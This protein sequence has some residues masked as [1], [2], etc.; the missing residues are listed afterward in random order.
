MGSTTY[1]ILRQQQRIRRA[2]D[3]LF[4]YSRLFIRETRP[5]RHEVEVF[6]DE[7]NAKIHLARLWMLQCCVSG[8]LPVMSL[9]SCA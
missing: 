8:L 3:K 2:G 9:G 4:L 7:L 6:C 1:V 5:S